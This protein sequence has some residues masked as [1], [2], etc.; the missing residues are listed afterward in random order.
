MAGRPHNLM[1]VVQ[2]AV[3]VMVVDIRGQIALQ[4]WM[5]RTAGLRQHPRSPLRLCHIRQVHY[6]TP[7]HPIQRPR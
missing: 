6:D 3:L 4:W 1:S 5:V 2:L 7:E